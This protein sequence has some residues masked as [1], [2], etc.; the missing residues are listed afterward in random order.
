LPSNK[1]KVVGEL[2]GS[3]NFANLANGWSGFARLDARVGDHLTG[4]TA[5]VG[6]RYQW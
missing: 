3:I 4:G 2:Q 5:R 1:D 6:L